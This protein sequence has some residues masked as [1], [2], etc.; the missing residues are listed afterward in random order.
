MSDPEALREATLRAFGQ[1][2]YELCAKLAYQGFPQV[3]VTVMHVLLISLQRLGRDDLIRRF[4]TENLPKLARYPA[5]QATIMMTIG[6]KESSEARACVRDDE[7][8]AAFHCCLGSRY[9]TQG[10]V[11]LAREQF[12][13]CERVPGTLVEKTLAR[14]QANW[15]SQEPGVLARNNQKLAAAMAE[16]N[17]LRAAGQTREAL[18]AAAAA[19]DAYRGD[20]TISLRHHLSIINNYAVCQCEVG[21]LDDAAAL[22]DVA[23]K[24]RDSA[25]VAEC[26]ETS[27]TQT[28][29]AMIHRRRGDN[30]AALEYFEHALGERKRALGEDA[31]GTISALA[32]IAIFLMELGRYEAASRYFSEAAAAFDRNPDADASLA[33]DLDAVALRLIDH[34]PAIREDAAFQRYAAR[35][36]NQARALMQ[37]ASI[38]GSVP[39]DELRDAIAGAKLALHGYEKPGLDTL[40]AYEMHELLARAHRTAGDYAAALPHLRALVDGFKTKAS[41]AM[42]QANV[43]FQ[44]GTTLMELNQFDEAQKTFERAVEIVRGSTEP[45]SEHY[46]KLMNGAAVSMIRVDAAKAETLFLEAS[47][48][49]ARHLAGRADLRLLLDQNRAASLLGQRK[50]SA[51][52][53]LLSELDAAIRRSFGA[54][55]FEYFLSLVMRGEACVA[56]GAFEEAEAHLNVVVDNPIPASREYARVRYRALV[57]LAHVRA[58]LG[59]YAG[60]LAA[61]LETHEFKSAEFEQV[62]IVAT[63]VERRRY[64]QQLYHELS[65]MLTLLE[66][67]GTVSED[68]AMEVWQFIVR[69]KAV[70]PEILMLR[71]SRAAF[72]DGDSALRNEIGTLRQRAAALEMTGCP[73]D[74]WRAR[75]RAEQFGPVP[76][77]GRQYDIRRCKTLGS[78]DPR[79]FCIRRIPQVLAHT[80]CDAFPS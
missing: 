66:R 17:R 57:A 50:F 25:V 78:R 52:R 23:L 80:F 71:R 49:V 77:Q 39:P 43:L 29:L 18:S 15:P 8:L 75:G 12:Q 10:Q 79:R 14:W 74:D 70:G 58:V 28:V 72:G 5:E 7:Q 32:N 24:I 60:A 45:L 59:R 73:T 20:L 46:I 21:N 68:L 38:S 11:E 37:N 44:L 13:L 51:V 61:L 69:C 53:K 67:I 9:L 56:E 40:P 6:L 33:S 65:I 35:R 16:L 64:F 63:D 26:F 22:C 48:L 1:R 31:P 36:G 54:T 41:S 55:S 4:E 76:P 30:D 2:D 42:A 3:T 34:R 47:D 19:F 27:V 62:S